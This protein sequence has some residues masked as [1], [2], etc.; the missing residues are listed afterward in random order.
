[1]SLEEELITRKSRHREPTLA[2]HPRVPIRGALRI[3]RS[4]PAERATR[5]QDAAGGAARHCS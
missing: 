2:A 1:M 3:D 4:S 5:T